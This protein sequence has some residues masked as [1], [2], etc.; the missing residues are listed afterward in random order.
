MSMDE[1]AFRA[2]RPGDEAVIARFVRALAVVEGLEAEVVAT[3]AHYRRALFAE[4]PRVFALIVEAA[5]EA[6]GFALWF[7]NYSTFNGLPGLYVEDVYVDAA[8][9]GR[10]IGTALFRHLARLAV[11]EGCGRMEWWVLDENTP[12][13]AFYRR[14]G[15]RAMNEWTVER[16]A[17]ATLAALAS[18]KG[19][20]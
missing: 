7:Y 17:G 4:H 12:A 8:W 5:G 14:I 1:Y 3:T 9:R 16:L 19:D 15:A 13:V 18:G 11:A 10:G 20:A 6:I 2:A